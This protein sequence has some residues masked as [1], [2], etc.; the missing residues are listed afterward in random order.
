MFLINKL[1]C[2]SLFEF[3]FKNVKL[4][5]GSLETF[6]YQSDR[7]HLLEEST[8]KMEQKIENLKQP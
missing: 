4:Y 5:K 6:T 1:C 2:I 3:S 7:E 8:F